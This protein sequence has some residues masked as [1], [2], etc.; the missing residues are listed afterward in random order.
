MKKRHYTAITAI[1]LL[2]TL[3]A[4]CATAAK[5][6]PLPAGAYNATDAGFYAALVTARGAIDGACQAGTSVTGVPANCIIKPELAAYKAQLN[7]AIASWN[8]AA[9]IVMTYRNALKNGGSPD[10]AAVTAAVTQVTSNTAAL[11]T[12]ISGGK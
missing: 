10:P 5:P 12:S 4:A 8:I 2:L 7:Q 11:V 9:P 3:T 1:A 6:K